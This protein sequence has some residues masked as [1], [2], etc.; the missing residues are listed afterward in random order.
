[1]SNH[2]AEA[3][4][5][6]RTAT[7]IL[8]LP[9]VLD[10]IH[11]LVAEAFELLANQQSS[12]TRKVELAAFLEDAGQHLQNLSSQVSGDTSTQIQNLRLEVHRAIA[13]LTEQTQ[14]NHR[15]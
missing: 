15:R 4:K 8:V 11:A 2:P 1:M 12:T 14:D 13:R 9:A 5:K 7:E 6:S 10:E 3:P